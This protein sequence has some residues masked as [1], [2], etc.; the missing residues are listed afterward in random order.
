MKK[1]LEQRLIDFAVM[2][3]EASTTIENSFTG[4][5]LSTQ[6]IR[7]SNS[8]ALNYG[9]AQSAES[10]KDFIHKISIV[11]KEL[12]ETYINLEL[13]RRGRLS[14]D[15][16]KHKELLLECEQLIK[17]F[18]STIQTAKNNILKN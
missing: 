16:Q 10:K 1:E 7:S 2:I 12:R 6:I 13:I 4:C 8:S 18:Y 5:H 3:M 17:I 15:V 9:E 11:L 14:S